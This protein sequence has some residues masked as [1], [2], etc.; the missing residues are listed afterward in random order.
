MTS[1]SST[2]RSRAAPLSASRVASEPTYAV[3]AVRLRAGARIPTHTRAHED[4]HLVVVDGELDACGTTLTPGEHTVLP[5][6]E[7]CRLVALTDVQALCIALPGGL[8]RLTALL[9][10]P[11]PSADDIRAHL[12]S[13]G[14]TLV[15]PFA[16]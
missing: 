2:R 6:G 1:K 14:V 5:R 4:L 7:P 9:D 10:E 15:P 8:E 11:V 13:A 16:R 3:I 12:T